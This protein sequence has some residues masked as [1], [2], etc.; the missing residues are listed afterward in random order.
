MCGGSLKF[1]MTK[2]EAEQSSA[3]K[4]NREVKKCRNATVLLICASSW[5]Y[6]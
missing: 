3:F 2:K 5:V 6:L 1:H 4:S